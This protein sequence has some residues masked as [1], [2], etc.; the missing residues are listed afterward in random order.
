MRIW[1]IAGIVMMLFGAGF[2][3]LF[4]ITMIYGG[5]VSDMHAMSQ[6]FSLS[7]LALFMA[8]IS[9]SRSRSSD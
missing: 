7:A 2:S 4:L 5:T 9:M 6:V 3:I 8:D 1:R